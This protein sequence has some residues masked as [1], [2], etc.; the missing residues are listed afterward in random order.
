[1]Y[2]WF[3]LENGYSYEYCSI[4]ISDNELQKIFD[5]IVI[6]EQFHDFF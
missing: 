1:M 4:G 5:G 2:L 3:D 6:K